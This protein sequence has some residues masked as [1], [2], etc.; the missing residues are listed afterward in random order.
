[1]LMQAVSCERILLISW[2]KVKSCISSTYVA[3]CSFS[4][5]ASENPARGKFFGQGDKNS[6]AEIHGCRAIPNLGKVNYVATE[7]A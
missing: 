4:L 3:L 5:R 6:L 2:N 7:I 1:M